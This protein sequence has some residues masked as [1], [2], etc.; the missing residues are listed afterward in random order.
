MIL[1]LLMCFCIMQA[2]EPSSEEVAHAT[3]L[4]QHY[5]GL[6]PEL[7][8]YAVLSDVTVTTEE[9]MP[10]KISVAESMYVLCQEGNGGRTR[11]DS[12]VKKFSASEM[13]EIDSRTSVIR[14]E[15][16]I[17]WFKNRRLSGSIKRDFEPDAREPLP[18]VVFFEPFEAPCVGYSA[19]T[20]RS[21]ARWGKG[22]L[23]SLKVIG[24][25]DDLRLIGIELLISKEEEVSFQ[26]VFDKST[27]LP[28]ECRLVLGKDKIPM[29]ITATK[30]GRF[31]QKFVP[32]EIDIVQSV[33]GQ[34]NKIAR[35]RTFNVKCTWSSLKPDSDVFES[36][37][38]WLTLDSN[39]LVGMIRQNRGKV[40]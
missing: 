26:I 34:K 18:E 13:R 25:Q 31:R 9:S 12:I 3:K 5:E 16:D 20:E 23:K 1:N 7:S 32:I 14:G 39:N 30:W 6:G 2:T 40:E 11:Y 33:L 19:F 21:V 24:Y 27:E 37:D 29:S 35:T 8:A 17:V 38:K 22:S 28:V 4:L 36:Q 15:S 10:P